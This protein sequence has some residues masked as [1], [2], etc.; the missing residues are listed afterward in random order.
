MIVK[1]QIISNNCHPSFHLIYIGISSLFTRNNVKSEKIH[2]SFMP[3]LTEHRYY[4][5]KCCYTMNS[6]STEFWDKVSDFTFILC[7]CTIDMAL[8]P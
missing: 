3:G 1:I 5:E 6:I 2:P 7:T 8:G 4:K